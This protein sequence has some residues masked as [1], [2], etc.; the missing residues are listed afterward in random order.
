MRHSKGQERIAIPRRQESIDGRYVEPSL[1]TPLPTRIGEQLVRFLSVT[2]LD[3]PEKL[4]EQ[5]EG[6]VA[7]RRHEFVKSG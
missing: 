7:Q 6:F 3:E 1:E 5:L 2:R 4:D